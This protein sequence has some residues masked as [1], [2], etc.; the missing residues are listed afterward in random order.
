ML[1]DLG[2]KPF[3]FPMPVLLIATYGEGDKVDVMN[4]A[5]GGI[6]AENMVAL[7]I[8]E[9]HKTTENLKKRGAFTLSIADIPHIAEAD[10]FGIATGNKMPDKFERT[11]LT[12]IRS[13]RVDAPI[14]AEFPLTLECKVLS[15]GEEKSGYRVLGE[16]VNVLADE[17]TLDEKGRV[18]PQKL[19]AFVFDQMQSGYYAIG[20]KVGKAWQSGA[21]LMKK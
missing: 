10:F 2:V 16:I 3:V 7:N 15:M 5:W 17:K 19:N 8:S 11:G 9:D 6:C 14:I 4:M 1:K 13:K 18:D 21:P 20:E 12:A